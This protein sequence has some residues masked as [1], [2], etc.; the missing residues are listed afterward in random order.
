M[1]KTLRERINEK[2]SSKKKSGIKGILGELR[3]RD[4][5]CSGKEATF[6]P[7]TIQVN[8]FHDKKLTVKHPCHS[9]RPSQI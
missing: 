3:V 7:C 6:R 2:I 8:L 9:V 1:E 4:I 5:V